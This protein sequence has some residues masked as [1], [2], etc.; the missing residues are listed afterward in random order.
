MERAALCTQPPHSLSACAWFGSRLWLP[1][2]AVEGLEEEERGPPWG[3]GSGRPREGSVLLL[4]SATLL[5]S[6]NYR[7]CWVPG[8][9]WACGEPEVTQTSSKLTPLLRPATR[10]WRPAFCEELQVVIICFS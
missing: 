3:G 2:P 6:S 8:S 1:R 9:C 10:A 4:S 7:W 5:R